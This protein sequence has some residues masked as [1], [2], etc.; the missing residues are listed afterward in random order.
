MLTGNLQA[1]LNIFWHVSSLFS[2]W[3]FFFES[4]YCAN[5]LAGGRRA[6]DK[7]FDP[8]ESPASCNHVSQLCKC[9]PQ[10]MQHLV[11]LRSSAL[12]LNFKQHH[13]PCLSVCCITFPQ[14]KES[15]LEMITRWL[16]YRTGFHSSAFPDLQTISHSP[17]VHSI[18]GLNCISATKCN[19][20]IFNFLL[21]RLQY[22][23][24]PF[25]FIVQRSRW[26]LN[27]I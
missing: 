22:N 9:Y 11:P 25:K 20:H 15:L 26:G 6:A 13:P 10:H 12:L 19:F 24:T 2:G 17:L 18:F 23:S 3:C 27:G 4:L 16:H 1:L 7:P 5:T 21:S 8:S 14:E